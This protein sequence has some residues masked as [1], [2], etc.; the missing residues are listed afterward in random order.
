MNEKLIAVND[1]TIAGIG[2]LARYFGFAEVMGRL[3]GTLLMSPEPMSL[4]DLAAQLEISK[5]SVSMNMRALERWGM[6]KEVWMRGDRKKYYAAEH[7]LWQVIRNVLSS[8]E[9]R[10]V[11]LALQVLGNS[12]E[13]LQS[14]GDEL[15]PADR[16]LAEFYLERIADLQAF[17][18]VAQM[19][20]ETVLGSDESVDFDA[21]TKIEIG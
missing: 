7:D 5:G 2:R 4:D 9:R 3:F 15:S 1:S 11:E 20:L 19:A 18:T 10:E 14:A 16:Q 12:V 17:F 13:K 21:V 6:A 8:R